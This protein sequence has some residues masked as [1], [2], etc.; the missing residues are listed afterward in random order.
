MPQG[1]HSPVVH[2][3]PSMLVK[4]LSLAKALG[5]LP[6]VDIGNRPTH[7]PACQMT[8][9][10]GMYAQR[11]FGHATNKAFAVMA[12]SLEAQAQPEL[13]REDAQAVRRSMS[14]LDPNQPERFGNI[15]LGRLAALGTLHAAVTHIR[16]SSP[17]DPKLV[18]CENDL[19]EAIVSIAVSSGK[20]DRP[21]EGTSTG[22][23]STRV[24][25]ELAKAGEC[26]VRC[27]GA[28]DLQE[29]VGGVVRGVLPEALTLAIGDRLAGQVEKLKA[30]GHDS[31]D[32]MNVLQ[33]RAAEKIRAAVEHLVRTGKVESVQNGLLMLLKIPQIVIEG[34]PGQKGPQNLTDERHPQPPALPRE[35]LDRAGGAPVLY[36]HS[37]TTVNN[38]F[39]DLVKA[40]DGR[41][42]DLNS[43]SNLIDSTRRD[44]YNLGRAEERVDRLLGLSEDLKQALEKKNQRICELERRLEAKNAELSRWLKGGSVDD[45]GFESVPQPVNR[46]EPAQSRRESQDFNRLRGEHAPPVEDSPDRV[47]VQGNAVELQHEQP[48]GL[49]E[50]LSVNAGARTSGT[51][52]ADEFESYI[53]ELHAEPDDRVHGRS[54]RILS[55]GEMVDARVDLPNTTVSV[56]DF[57]EFQRVASVTQS[58]RA[59]EVASPRH[60]VSSQMAGSDSNVSAFSSMRGVAGRSSGQGDPQ[61]VPKPELQALFDAIARKRESGEVLPLQAV[62]RE[63]RGLSHSVGTQEAIRQGNRI[64]SDDWRARASNGSSVTSSFA[65]FVG[66]LINV[67]PGPVDETAAERPR[68]AGDEMVVQKSMLSR[69]SVGDSRDSGLGEPVASEEALKDVSS[70]RRADAAKLHS[71]NFSALLLA[72]IQ[73]KRAALNTSAPFIVR[74]SSGKGWEVWPG[75]RA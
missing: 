44:A 40:L 71:S 63:Q 68:S 49:V 32:V 35:L 67:E 22:G 3:L 39:S 58:P 43:L 57:R 72:E 26:M 30:Q 17:N 64:L 7:Y 52:P 14:W 19:R 56:A 1:I 25:A 23:P 73:A 50:A 37:P 46:G 8:N 24:A 54:R 34:Q 69:A 11:A 9:V 74:S 36:N 31:L 53:Q 21:P 10:S 5:Q 70:S 29:L 33:G 13:S 45:V 20:C 18:E 42:L 16:E 47:R 65:E 28:L 38:D 12:A 4:E 2:S 48:R 6:L 15:V 75:Q 51:S 27:A 62:V 61:A 55:D 41:G 66:E 59:S 60:S